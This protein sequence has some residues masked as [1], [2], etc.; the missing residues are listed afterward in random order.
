MPRKRPALTSQV[1]FLDDESPGRAGIDRFFLLGAGTSSDKNGGIC[2]G[3]PI[4]GL[5]YVKPE[6]IWLKD[7]PEGV[8]SNVVF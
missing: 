6:R 2:R 7:H 3:A 1:P 5:T 4:M 8:F